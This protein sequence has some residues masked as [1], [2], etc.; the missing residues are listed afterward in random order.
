MIL[1]D[2]ELK[3]WLQTRR[4]SVEPLSEDSVQQ[5]GVDLKIGHEIARLHNPSVEP[6]IEPMIFDAKSPKKIEHFYKKE[7]IDKNGFIIHPGEQILLSTEEYVTLPT[8]LMGFC[9]L[10]STL[11]RL[12]IKI[13]PTNIDAGFSGTLTIQLTGGTFQIKL[14][15][16]MRF[17]HVIFAKLTTAVENPYRGRYHKQTGVTLPR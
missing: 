14:Y 8:D 2:F 12:G 10:R 3:L 6:T 16:G 9:E 1:S 13:P 5:N 15:P 11:A 17:L 7:T 4:L